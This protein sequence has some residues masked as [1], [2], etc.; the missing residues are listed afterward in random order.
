MAGEYDSDLAKKLNI[1]R[2]MKVRVLD[3]PADV[4]LD[5]LETT[6]AADA[7]AVLVFVV[8]QADVDARFDA[9]VAAAD[10]G[11]IAWI[12]YPKAKQL[13]TDLNRDILAAHVGGRGLKPVRQVAIDETWSALRFRRP[14]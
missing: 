12:A 7:D 13:G 5:G 14:D 4:T 11:R 1:K 6:S 8:R 9:V 3:R 2:G 10:A